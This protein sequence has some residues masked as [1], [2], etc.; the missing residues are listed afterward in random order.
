MI[1]GYHPS[2]LEEVHERS[3]ELRGEP[4]SVFLVRLELRLKDGS[5][6]E[7]EIE[8][9]PHGLMYEVWREQLRALQR[10]IGQVS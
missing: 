3:V 4:S 5:C 6:Q 8:F 7:V 1:G 2:D 10:L 9:E